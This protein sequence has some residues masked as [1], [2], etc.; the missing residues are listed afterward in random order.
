MTPLGTCIGASG[1]FQVAAKWFVEI[2]RREAF[3][4]DFM[5]LRRVQEIS[6]HVL[7]SY[8]KNLHRGHTALKTSAAKYRVPFGKIG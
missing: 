2:L 4:G 7:F 1:K 5:V 6:K 8:C 3:Y